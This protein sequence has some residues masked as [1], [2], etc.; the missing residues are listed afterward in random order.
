MI[1]NL[2]TSIFLCSSILLI[3]NTVATPAP[4]R[5]G[6]GFRGGSSFGGS[7]PV[8]PVSGAIHAQGNSRQ[9]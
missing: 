1:S 8:I 6:G 3:T 2:I 7:G 4:K 5:G 9:A